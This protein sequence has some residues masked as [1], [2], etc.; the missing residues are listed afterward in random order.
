MSTETVNIEM[1]DWTVPCWDWLSPCV[2][3]QCGQASQS[4]NTSVDTSQF[5]A[6]AILTFGGV[7]MSVSL[8]VLCKHQ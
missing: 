4:Q 6:A 1:S 7:F 8:C 3:S 2:D 5:G